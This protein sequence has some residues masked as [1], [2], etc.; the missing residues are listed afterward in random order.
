MLILH[1]GHTAT[2][3]SAV[4]GGRGNAW[5]TVKPVGRYFHDMRRVLLLDDEA[6][7]VSTVSLYAHSCRR[8]QSFCCSDSL[9]MSTGEGMGGEDSQGGGRP[10]NAG[11]ICLGLP[12]AVGHPF[13]V[14]GQVTI[15]LPKLNHACAWADAIWCLPDLLSP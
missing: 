8:G 4:K 11:S 9:A 2:A 14:N 1:R 3:P 15:L 5:D 13:T 10:L 6:C 12:A 7:K